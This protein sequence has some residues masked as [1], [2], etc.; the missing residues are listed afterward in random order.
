MPSGRGSAWRSSPGSAFQLCELG[1]AAGT[2]GAL[3][4][5]PPKGTGQKLSYFLVDA[6]III[7]R[8]R[9]VG[10]RGK[11]FLA[12][13]RCT[14]RLMARK[15][16]SGDRPG[17]PIPPCLLLGA[18]SRDH[19]IMDFNESRGTCP[20]LGGCADT[21]RGCPELVSSCLQ[22]ATSSICHPLSS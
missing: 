9:R 19:S 14:P 18:S 11:W 4:S 7:P 12:H 5:P 22:S 2:L 1:Q 6:S 13:S 15:G 8:T 16:G 3:I 21:E 10:V 17:V 20:G